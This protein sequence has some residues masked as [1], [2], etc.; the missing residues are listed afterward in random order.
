MKRRGNTMAWAVGVSA[1]VHLLFFVGMALLAAMNA[2]AARVT[3]DVFPTRETPQEEILLIAEAPPP[4]PPPEPPQEFIQTDPSR[5]SDRP[6]HKSGFISDRDTL[7]ASKFP[8]DPRGERDAPTQEGIDVPAVEVVA[9]ELID[10]DDPAS[11]AAR[12]LEAQP[13]LQSA[14]MPAVELS[15]KAPSASAPPVPSVETVATTPDPAASLAVPTPEPPRETPAELREPE[16]ED[17]Q[18]REASPKPPLASPATQPPAVANRPPEKPSPSRFQ[19]HRPLTK[20]RGTIS[21]RGE[22]SVDAADTPIGRYMKEVTS[23]I[24]REWHRKRRNYADFVTYGTIRLDFSV[25]KQGKIEG[26]SIKNR[27]GANAI[28]QDFTL[29]AVLDA[30][31]PPMPADLPEIL[32]HDRLPI[33]YDIIVY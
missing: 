9:H 2:F 32:D 28:M 8:P 15:V 26:L 21:N 11:A 5:S 23:A 25:N 29:N 7:A 17:T 33:T 1:A 14:P 13:G 12:Q 18:P 24:E 27:S 16:L 10:G 4:L 19:A 31:I 30:R 6:P 22:T 3:P 20:L